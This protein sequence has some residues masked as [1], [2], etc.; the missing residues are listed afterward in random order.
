MLVDRSGLPLHHHRHEGVAL[1]VVALA[2]LAFVATGCRGP[3]HERSARAEAYPVKA[4]PFE[5]VW[6]LH[7]LD[8]AS[9]VAAPTLAIDGTRF[10]LEGCGTLRGAVPAASGPRELIPEGVGQ[11]CSERAWKEHQQLVAL[12][13]LAPA[14]VTMDDAPPGCHGRGLMLSAGGH[15]A[16]FCPPMPTE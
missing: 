16:I 5:G 7:L 12:L 14:P 10:E 2:A 15:T 6:R 11:S 8:G 4:A 9:S 13:R 1:H 3:E